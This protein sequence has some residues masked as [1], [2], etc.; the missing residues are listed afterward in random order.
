MYCLCILQKSYK[1]FLQQTCKIFSIEQ[2][3]V[4]NKLQCDI[5]ILFFGHNI[6]YNFSKV[7]K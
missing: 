4:Y 6:L 3:E 5:Y 1:Y 2:I 7:C